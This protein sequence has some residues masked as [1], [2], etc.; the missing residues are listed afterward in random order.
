MAA[1]KPIAILT[2][3]CAALAAGCASMGGSGAADAAAGATAPTPAAVSFLAADSNHD[4]RI[5]PREFAAWQR[6]RGDSLDRED[7]QAADANLDGLLTLDE[8]TQMTSGAR[9]AAGGSRAPGGRP[10][11]AAQPPIRVPPSLPGGG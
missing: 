1:K 3:S 5:S 6:T 4:G 11:P 10:G 9:A 7:F 8:W 2:F